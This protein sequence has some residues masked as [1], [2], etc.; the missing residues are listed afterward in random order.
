MNGATGEEIDTAEFQAALANLLVDA[1]LRRR[2]AEEPA[3]FRL[4]FQLSEPQLAA[5]QHAGIG[6]LQA[7][8]QDL[9]EKRV[10]IFSKMCPNTF[11]LLRRK[12]LL[13]LVASRFIAEH[14][15]RASP[16]YPNRSI[17]DFFWFTDLVGRMLERGEIS[18][19]YLEGVLRCERLQGQLSSTP[20]ALRSARRA[21]AA[22]AARRELSPPEVL[23]GRPRL[24]AHA[25]VETFSHDIVRIM[26]CLTQ[27]EQ[28]P[29][30]QPSTTTLL[31][32][33]TVGWRRVQVVSINDLTRRLIALCD[34]TRTTAEIAQAVAG[35]GSGPM[36]L[37]RVTEGCVGIL[38]EMLRHHAI[39]L[40]EDGSS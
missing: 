2:F 35:E 29:V 18:C 37:A 7:F 36:E 32:V 22:S 10:E 34:G 39:C 28:L 6:R 17:R 25:V 20:E 5:L 9:A 40:E 16:E 1:A 23:A 15:P 4:D 13:S 3:R 8:A 24:G 26:R 12:N 21:R 11:E 33:K 30:L 27:G 19:D 14:P 38:H 31:L